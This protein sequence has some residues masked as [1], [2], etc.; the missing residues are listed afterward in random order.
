MMPHI[1]RPPEAIAADRARY[2]EHQ[3]KGL[4]FAPKALPVPSLLPAP[5]PQGVLHEQVIPGGWYATLAMQSGQILRL[6]VGGPGGSVSMAAWAADDC[7]ERLNLPDTVKV[8]WTTD[9][10]KGRVLFSDMG[11]VMLSITEDSSGAH[12]ALTGGSGPTGEGTPKQRNTRENMILAAAKLGLD[13]RDLPMLLTFFAPVRVDAA[14]RFFWQAALLSGADWVDLRAEM[15]LQIALSNTR[16]PLDP[17]TGE[18]PA[19]MAIL[20]AARPVPEDDL[21][22]TA[23]PE[24][25]RGFENN[26]RG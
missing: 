11:R 6:L 9:L 14:G 22:R 17:A 20:Q 3:R 24:A 25:I 15:P 19:A 10:R 8:Q 2:D 21:C 16:H 23:T 18:V 26:A 1:P 13:R 12:D 4:T 7:S 5:A